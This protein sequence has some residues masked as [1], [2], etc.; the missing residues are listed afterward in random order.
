[1]A[2]V[3]TKLFKTKLDAWRC[4]EGGGAL[5]AVQAA[6]ASTASKSMTPVGYAV[7]VAEKKVCV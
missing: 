7:V 1:M 3:S 5:A 4:G 2:E 6:A